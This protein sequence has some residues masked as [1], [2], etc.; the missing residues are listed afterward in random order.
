MKSKNDLK[1]LCIYLPGIRHDKEPKVS[2]MCTAWGSGLP[3]ASSGVRPH[4]TNTHSQDSFKY[5]CYVT[6]NPLRKNQSDPTQDWSVLTGDGCR[7]RIEPVCGRQA[8]APTKFT[9]RENHSGAD[10]SERA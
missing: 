6:S 2:S 5:I 7:E 1:Y 9:V 4:D 10:R 3:S 8:S